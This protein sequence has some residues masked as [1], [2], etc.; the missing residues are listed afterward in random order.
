[1]YLLNKLSIN[2]KKW[3]LI[4]DDETL[5]LD[6]VSRMLNHLG[7]QTLRAESGKDAIEIFSKNCDQLGLV[8]LDMV[9]LDMEGIEV[10]E[11]LKKID[12]EIKVILSSGLSPDFYSEIAVR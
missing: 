9:L 12:R 3:V 4:V 11:K 6:V 1:M 8:I 5:V 10:F 2:R 7:Y